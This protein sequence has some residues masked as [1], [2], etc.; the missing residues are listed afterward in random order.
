LDYETVISHTVV[1]HATDGGTL[2]LTGTAT[3]VI[4]V[5]PANDN[6]PVFTDPNGSAIINETTP[7]G[8]N[9]YN[10]TATDSDVGTGGKVSYYIISGNGP[11]N[12]TFYINPN[13]GVTYVWSVLDYDTPPQIYNL[14]L[15]A[16]DSG[17]LFDTMWL[18][19]TLTDE[20]D[21]YPVFTQNTYNAAINEDVTVGTPVAQIVANDADSGVNGQVTYS[22]VSG[23]GQTSFEINPATGNF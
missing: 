2:K 9:I 20:N 23:D 8:T 14:T 6:A 1:V 5:L 12:T 15:K 19:I 13:Q 17:G 11:S 21:E 7:V 18:S 22:I 16:E 4:N 10:A 3:V